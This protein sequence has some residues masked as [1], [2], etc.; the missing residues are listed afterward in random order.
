M[1]HDPTKYGTMP[2]ISM[3]TGHQAFT[4]I[5]MITVISVMAILATIGIPSVVSANKRSSLSHG[6]AAI[7]DSWRQA[8]TLALANRMPSDGRHFG[9]LIIRDTN[10]QSEAQVVLGTGTPDDEIISRTVLPSTVTV[11]IGGINEVRWFAQYGSG[12]PITA[13]A[14]SAGDGALATPQAVG[15]PGQPW[16]PSVTDQVVVLPR[17]ATSIVTA[18]ASTL[19]IHIDA[20]G[21]DRLVEGG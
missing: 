6:G 3:H 14:V 21:H 19:T 4:L 5:E 9:V 11:D 15:I 12:A 1:N 20:C 13:I 10:G 16:L 18:G 17:N 2:T 7:A 8:R